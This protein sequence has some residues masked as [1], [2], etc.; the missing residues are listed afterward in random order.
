MTGR[1]LD[2]APANTNV[3]GQNDDIGIDFRRCEAGKLGM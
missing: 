1:P 3:A 2:A